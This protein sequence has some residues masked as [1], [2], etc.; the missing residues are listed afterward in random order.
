MVFHT[1]CH[2]DTTSKPEQVL[3][4]YKWITEE[5]YSSNR[6]GDGVFETP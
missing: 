4:A 1:S 2:S 6:E 3:T 5:N